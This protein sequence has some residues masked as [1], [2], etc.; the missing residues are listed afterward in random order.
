MEVSQESKNPTPGH[1]PSLNPKRHMY[2]MLIVALLTIAETWKKPK[3][4]PTDEFIEWNT[5]NEILF[6]H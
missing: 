2:P 1:T 5:Y 3:S 4:P 6:G